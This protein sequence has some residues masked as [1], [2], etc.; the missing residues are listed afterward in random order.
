MLTEKE[1]EH[2][3]A[4]NKKYGRRNVLKHY[5]KNWDVPEDVYQYEER[6]ITQ[7]PIEEQKEEDIPTR[8]AFDLDSITTTISYMQDIKDRLSQ[9]E[10]EKVEL[11]EKLN[12]IE[13]EY[14]QLT[15]EYA[16]LKDEV[17]GIL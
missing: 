3:K 5:D 13:A 4:L 14:N 1:V 12:D 6:E 9:I 17:I 8:K 2:L 10:R 16:E 15:N 7:T 11:T